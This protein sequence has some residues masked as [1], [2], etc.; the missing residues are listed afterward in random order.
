LRPGA[1]TGEQASPKPTPAM[2]WQDVHLLDVHDL[3]PH[4]G[5]RCTIAKKRR[6]SVSSSSLLASIS[7]AT[8]TGKV[9]SIQ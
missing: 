9:A 7:S 1:D 5:K 8:G 3:L 2:G 6:S 4:C